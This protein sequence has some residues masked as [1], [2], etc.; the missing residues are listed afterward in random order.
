[1]ADRMR[2]TSFIDSTERG[3]RGL[4]SRDAWN[5]LTRQVQSLALAFS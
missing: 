5:T 3:F 4:D 1:M 2:V